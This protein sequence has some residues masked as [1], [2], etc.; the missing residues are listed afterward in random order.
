MDVWLCPLRRRDEL[1][2]LTLDHGRDQAGARESEQVR[3]EGGS[4]LLGAGS[5]RQRHH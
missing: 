5:L 3:G 2:L 4:D 1:G